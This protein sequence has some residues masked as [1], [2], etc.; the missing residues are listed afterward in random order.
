MCV[1]TAPARVDFL[2]APFISFENVSPASYGSHGPTN[3]TCPWKRVLHV[4]FPRAD[5][6][7]KRAQS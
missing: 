5:E 1:T 3:G 6:L 2:N 7:L 4:R